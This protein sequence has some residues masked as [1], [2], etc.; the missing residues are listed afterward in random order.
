MSTT[1]RKTVLKSI[2]IS[3]TEEEILRK[4]AESKGITFNAL[5]S[6]LITRYIEWDRLAERYGFIALPRQSFRYLISLL[7][8]KQ[9][10]K[11]GKETG[12]RNAPAI[13]LFW[14]KRLDRQTFLNFISISAKYCKIWD[15]EVGRQGTDFLL[16]VHNDIDPAY[17][18]V[19]RHYFDQAIRSIVGAVPKVEDKGNAVVFTFSEPA[20]Q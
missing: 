5:V 13:T 19:H 3:K 15:Y 8:E 2:R 16:T 14:F 18:V 17:S 20:S 1:E 4:D 12:L 9:L 10:E 7:D 6:T 11:F